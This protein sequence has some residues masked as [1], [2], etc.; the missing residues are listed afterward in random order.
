MRKQVSEHDDRIHKLLHSGLRITATTARGR[1]RPTDI[2]LR[3]LERLEF[4]LLVRR[5]L[6][7]LPGSANPLRQLPL[8]QATPGA[9]LRLAAEV[10]HL[11]QE[12][13]SPV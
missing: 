4:C 3:P 7:R 11:L 9:L 2:A 6:L 5:E 12:L 8:R 10:A 13:L 1:L